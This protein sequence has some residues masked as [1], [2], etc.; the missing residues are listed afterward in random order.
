[1]ATVAWRGNDQR[2]EGGRF[3]SS[4]TQP[5]LDFDEVFVLIGRQACEAH[6]GVGRIAVTSWLDQCGKER[7]LQARYEHVAKQ[8]KGSPRGP[9]L[10]PRD[11]SLILSQAFPAERRRVTE[12]ARE[13]AQYLRIV[14]NGGFV[15]SATPD[16]DWYVG[17]SRRTSSE[18][19][20]MA[21]T[22]G[23]SANLTGD[24]SS[25]VE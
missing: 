7:L 4:Y 20:D 24:G 17:L 11:M 15:I 23:F 19:V 21:K 5:P 1:M 8:G 13:A 3:A 12:L 6:Y 16:G 25:E 14:R 9:A 18:L 2:G 22:R 10:T